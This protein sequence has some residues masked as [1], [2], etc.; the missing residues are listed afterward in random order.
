MELTEVK[1]V[2]DSSADV[3][4]I[5]NVAYGVAS[6]KM[7]TKVGEYVDDASLD[8]EKM[9]DELEQNDE[10]VT[11][12]CPSEGD[13][14]ETFGDAKYVFCVTITS[15]LSGSYN[16]ACL[17]KRDYEEKYPDRK[18]YVVDSLS[19]GPEMKLI[20]EKLRELIL[21][22][23][24][25]ESICKEIAQYQKTTALVFMLQSLRNLKTTVG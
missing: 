16:S 13:W 23:K 2:A 4:E 6:L 11:T 17:A 21:A 18:V 10:K 9:I 1:I 25:F 5:E 24:D 14:L 22:G 8:V 19:T 20:I 15:N 3:L 7:I 12:A